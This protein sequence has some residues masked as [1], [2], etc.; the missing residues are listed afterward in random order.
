MA[1]V[2][3]RVDSS[4]LISTLKEL[5]KINSV[6]PSLV[7]GGAGEAEIAAF[8][9]DFLENIGLDVEL[10]EV[11]KDRPNVIGILR[12]KDSGPSLI[13]NGHMDT[14]G[15]EG[16]VDPFN[17]RVDGNNIYG[18]GSADM[19]GGLASILHAVKTVVDSEID[20]DGD[21]IVASVVDEEYA[22]LGT[23]RLVKSLRADAAVVCECTGLEIGV[24]H[25]GFV[26]LEVETRG[27]AA[28]GSRPE[29]GI[30]AIVKMGK[31]LVELDDFEAKILSGRSH[32]LLGHPSVHAS[33]IE[34]GKELSTYPDQCKLKLERRT[35]PGEDLRQVESELLSILERLSG[36]DPKFNADLRTIF[37]RGPFTVST[38]EK[39][40]RS[41]R[42]AI[43][44]AVGAEP[45]FIGSYG[46]LD[47]EI[48]QNAGVPT[49]IF[50]PGG[51]GAHSTDEYVYADQV[52]K[53][54]MVLSQLI[55]DFCKS[56]PP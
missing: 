29:E 8:I 50:G 2:F 30:D 17:P 45:R 37:A 13:L 18:R 22:S 49:V 36:N 53:A 54:A 32:R 16:M 42:E 10:Y 7:P 24:A 27:K 46:W 12:G 39:V 4:E 35:I 9:A 1:T 40:V 41:L 56:S 31:F 14:V 44:K 11:D 6:N 3:S 38:K 20:L 33:L 47:S 21:L 23:E 43:I 28:H 51:K 15:V 34:G 5:I 52:V 26:W 48:I 55:I 25:K 19:K